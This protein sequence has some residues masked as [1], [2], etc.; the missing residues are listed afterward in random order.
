MPESTVTLPSTALTDI[1]LLKS[2]VGDLKSSQQKQHEELRDQ[3]REISEQIRP[4]ALLGHQISQ[5]DGALARC[6]AE[7]Q[8]VEDK[9][10]GHIRHTGDTE[11]KVWIAH[12]ALIGFA[13][14]ITFVVGLLTWEAVD[15]IQQTRQGHADNTRDIK[16]VSDMHNQDFRKLSDRVRELELQRR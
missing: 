13:A 16:A 6:F 9:L 3:L 10:D 4:I 5:Q 14:V 7:V 1:E 2:A 15:F 12:G 8:N 11:R